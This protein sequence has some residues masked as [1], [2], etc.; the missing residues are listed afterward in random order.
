MS[1]PFGLQKVL[2]IVGSFVI[3]EQGNIFGL[4]RKKNKQ[5]N[6]EKEFTSF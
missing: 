1:L 2:D 4:L 3:L 6:S 5:G